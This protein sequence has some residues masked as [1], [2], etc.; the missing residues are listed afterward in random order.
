[1]KISSEKDLGLLIGKIIEF[2][3]DLALHEV[4]K[5]FRARVIKVNYRAYKEEENLHGVYIDFSEFRSHNEQFA[6]SIYYTY[7]K[8]YLV[9]VFD[10]ADYSDQYWTY[11]D[12]EN[13]PFK[14]VG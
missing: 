6:K 4:D 1:M 12:G 10:V 7:N 14:I 2:H 11:F 9:K 5:E 13:L 3:S 8:P